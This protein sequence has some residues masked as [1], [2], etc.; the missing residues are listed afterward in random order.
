MRGLI[1]KKMKLLFY[2]FLHEYMYLIRVTQLISE[3][4]KPISR[5]NWRLGHPSATCIQIL[6]DNLRYYVRTDDKV[7][8]C[9]IEFSMYTIY[10]DKIELKLQKIY[11]FTLT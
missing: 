7:D 2:Y 5:A 1:Y 10:E 4:S 6:I 11:S 8:L 3:F 9:F